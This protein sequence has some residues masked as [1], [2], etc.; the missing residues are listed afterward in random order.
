MA[1]TLTAGSL[2]SGIGG[3]DLAFSQ[4]GFDVRWQVER[5]EFCRSVLARD[6]PDAQRLG[7]IHDVRGADLPPVDVIVAGFPCQ[8]FSVAGKRQGANDERY[9]VPEMLRVI[10]EVRPYVFLLENVPGFA[11]LNAGGE[12]RELLRQIAEMGYDAEWGRIRASDVEAPHRR[13]RWFLVAY[14]NGTGCKQHSRGVAI[15]PKQSTA[16]CAGG[17][18]AGGQIEPGVRGNSNGL[19]AGLHRHQWP[20]RPGEPQHDWEPPRLASGVK[21][22]TK[23]IKALG[24]AV[25]PQQVYPLALAIRAFLEAA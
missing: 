19:P 13:E 1:R 4:A 24:N 17:G 10:G 18:T 21:D 12:F 2:F 22:R 15:Q 6:W 3:I 11:S 5:E 7:D 8:P 23:R 14:S 9:L 25:V 16:Q 20:A